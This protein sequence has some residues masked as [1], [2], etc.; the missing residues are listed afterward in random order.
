LRN[1][2]GVMRRLFENPVYREVLTAQATCKK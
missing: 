2:P 1:A